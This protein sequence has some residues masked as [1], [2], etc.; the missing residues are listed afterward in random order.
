MLVGMLRVR[1]RFWLIHYDYESPHKGRTTRMCGA[2]EG[3]D[4]ELLS[5]F[6]LS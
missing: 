4:L 3:S 2:H 1:V 6:G 5:D